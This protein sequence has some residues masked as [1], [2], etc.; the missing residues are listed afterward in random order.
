LKYMQNGGFQNQPL[1]KLTLLFAL[2]LLTGFW[3]TNFT[4]YFAKMGVSPKSVTDYYR[5]SEENF[6]MPRTSQSMLEVTHAHLATQAIVILLITHLFIFTPYATKVKVVLIS[7]GFMFAVLNESSGWLVR[8]VSPNFA[9]LKVISFLCFQIVLGMLIFILIAF[10]VKS[11]ANN[12]NHFK[13]N[14][15]KNVAEET[16]KSDE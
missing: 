6:T 3:V 5:G 1:M 12:A 10:L 9:V 7:S 14:F 15:N 11:K 8:F 2:L 16:M 13:V 4:L